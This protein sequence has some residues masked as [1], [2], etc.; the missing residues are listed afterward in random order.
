MGSDKR[1]PKRRGAFAFTAPATPLTV[2]PPRF[3]REA[4]ATPRCTFM[5]PSLTQ[6][7]CRVS[8]RGVISE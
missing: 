3:S 2:H 7:I 5:P 6:P 1:M 4:D 8:W